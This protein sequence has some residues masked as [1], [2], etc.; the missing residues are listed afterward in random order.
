MHAD[1]LLKLADYLEQVVA[2]LPA[3]S[4]SLHTWAANAPECGTVC[5][6]V[7]HGCSIPEFQAAG[8]RLVWNDDGAEPWLGEGETNGGWDA[9]TTFFGIEHRNASWLFSGGRY[10]SH[11]SPTPADVAQRISEFVTR[12][13]SE[14]HEVAAP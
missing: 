11:P 7:G 9:V 8:L 10:P 6:A 12:K 4:F 13:Q 2:K 5:C 1:R 3:E 14:V